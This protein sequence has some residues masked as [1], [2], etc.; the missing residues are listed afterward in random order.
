MFS[1]L[2]LLAIRPLHELDVVYGKVGETEVK[3]DIFRPE[4]PIRTPVPAV[5]VIHGGAWISG[6]KAD[7]RSVAQDLAKRG[8]VAAAVQYRLAP[9]FKWPTMV[10]D[11]QTAVRYVR[12]NAAKL[13]VDPQRIG[14]IGFSAGAHL[15]LLLGTRD[16][17][18]PNPIDNPKVSSRVSVVID[19]FGPTDLTVE[20]D[21][22]KSFDPVFFTV[23]GKPKAQ[24]AEELKDGSPYVHLSKDDAPTFIYQGLTDPLVN[25]NQSRKLEAKL[26]ELRVP[27]ESVYLEGIGH[28]VPVGKPDVSEAVEKAYKFLDKHLGGK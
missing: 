24:A 6:T 26:K 10:D 16:T 1:L 25:P 17:R 4:T 27:V 22:P 28:E 23:L 21:Y 11:V 3:M 19:F 20:A 5:L 15:S 18:D 13:G 7:V 8:Y 2:V 14:A 12:A 9:K